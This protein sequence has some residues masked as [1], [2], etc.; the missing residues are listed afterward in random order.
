MKSTYRCSDCAFIAIVEVKEVTMGAGLSLITNRPVHILCTL[1]KLYH[2]PIHPGGRYGVIEGCVRG[3][4]A[5]VW[6]GVNCKRQ[7]CTKRSNN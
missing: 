6:R 3:H 1:L 2:L 4:L 7:T 5:M